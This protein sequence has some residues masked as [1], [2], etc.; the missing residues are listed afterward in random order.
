MPECAKNLRDC[1]KRLDDPAHDGHCN[2]HRE[3]G[4]NRRKLRTATKKDN[5]EKKF[6]AMFE[7]GDN[8]SE[9]Q[10]VKSFKEALE[11]FHDSIERDEQEAALH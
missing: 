5:H 10:P 11:V 3:R 8:K 7:R 1:S 6:Q 9:T 4:D 2:S